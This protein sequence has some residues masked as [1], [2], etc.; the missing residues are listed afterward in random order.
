MQITYKFSP[1]PTPERE[2]KLLWTLEKCRGGLQS[3]AR[4]I[5]KTGNPK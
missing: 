5:E 1:Y 3:N 4:R 2:K